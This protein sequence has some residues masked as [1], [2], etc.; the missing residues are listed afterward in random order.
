MKTL[1]IAT[2]LL[3]L[4]LATVEARAHQW[5]QKTVSA[6]AGELAKALDALLADPNLDAQQATAMQQR[7]HEAAISTARQVKGLVVEYKKRID[8]G[9]SRD[10]SKP[11]WAQINE[12]RGD[13][14]AYARKSWL[15]PATDRKADAVS[16]LFD[17]LAHYY[18]SD[19]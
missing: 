15:P 4:C 8:S 5:D 19:F 18:P 1:R 3:A 6:T 16:A 7:E 2:L 17:Q 12:L 11:F 10:D 13:I 9:Y 14:Q